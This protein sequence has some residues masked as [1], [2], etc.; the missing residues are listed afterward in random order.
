MGVWASVAREL[1]WDEDY[2]FGSSDQDFAWRAQLGGYRLA[3]APD[4][5]VHLRFRRQHRCH[6]E[7][8]LSLRPLGGP[9]PPRLPARRD[10]Q[11]RQP[12]RP[13]AL[14]AARG[15]DPRPVGLPRAPGKLDSHRRIS[16]RL[17]DGQRSGPGARSMNLFLLG[18]RRS[19]AADSGRGR[20]AL[21]TTLAQL[22]YFDPGRAETWDA[23]SGRATLS[24]VGHEPE[25]VG[26]TRYVEADHRGMALFSGRPFRWTEDG[27]ADGRAPST[28]ASTAARRANGRPTSTDAAPRSAAT[29]SAA[30][31]SS[32]PTPWAPTPCTQASWT[33]RAGSATARSSCAPPLAADELDASAIAS[34]IGCGHTLDGDPIW[35]RVRQAAQRGGSPPGRRGGRH[36]DRPVAAG[37]D[38]VAGRRRVRPGA[39]RRHPGLR[40]CGPRRLAGAPDPDPALG[41]PGFPPGVRGGGGGGS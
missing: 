9:A 15:R 37:A 32:T 41:R 24:W 8:V 18:W 13:A 25:R 23:P 22:P 38:R 3:F 27:G 6:R 36:Q 2:R 20:A 11:A 30:S 5:L 1:G 21:G 34:V 19:G 7:A 29:T 31:W 40:D 16:L 17:P 26:G 4:A 33:A 10:P 39:S 35:A 12:R 28:P 14:V